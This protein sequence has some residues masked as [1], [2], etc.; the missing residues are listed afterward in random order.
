MRMTSR[1]SHPELMHL[2]CAAAWFRENKTLDRN[3]HGVRSANATKTV[4]QEKHHAA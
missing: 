2:A 4:E 1:G 3:Q